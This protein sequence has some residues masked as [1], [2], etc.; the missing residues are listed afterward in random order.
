MIKERRFSPKFDFHTGVVTKISF[1]ISIIL[2]I[3][4]AIELLLNM[5]L[6]LDSSIFLALAI[7]FLGFT[8]ISW[9]FYSQF[10]KL[11]EIVTELEN[12]EFE[13]E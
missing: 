8:G 13:Q 5:T 7:L 9:F 10:S 12:D 3:I 2:L 1:V 11:S 4:V 6:L